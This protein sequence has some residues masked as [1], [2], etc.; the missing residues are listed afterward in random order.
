MVDKRPTEIRSLFGLYIIFPFFFFV[1]VVFVSNFLPMQI[2]KMQF[3]LYF[4]KEYRKITKV[5]LMSSNHDIRNAPMF[6]KQKI[7]LKR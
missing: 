7:A 1:A 2:K 4:S 3:L 5:L 6:S